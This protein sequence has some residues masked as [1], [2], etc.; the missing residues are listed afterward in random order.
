ME[1]TSAAGTGTG[2]PG[3]TPEHFNGREDRL[4]TRCELEAHNAREAP[5]G[6]IWLV[7]FPE[8]PNAKKIA[9]GKPRCEL[10]AKN[11][12][13]APTGAI[14]LVKFLALFGACFGATPP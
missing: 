7:K 10:E 3:C 11:A 4:N 8:P 13:E 5:N 14:W 12:R 1:T 6:A 9:L 2:L